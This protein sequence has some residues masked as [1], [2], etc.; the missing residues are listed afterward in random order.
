MLT[1]ERAMKQIRN[2]SIVLLLLCA[3]STIVAQQAEPQYTNVWYRFWQ[4]LDREFTASDAGQ[5]L[6]NSVLQQ[7][8]SSLIESINKY[9]LNR[10]FVHGITNDKAALLIKT[11]MGRFINRRDRIP[12]KFKYENGILGFDERLCCVGCVYWGKLPLHQTSALGPERGKQGGEHANCIQNDTSPLLNTYIKHI[13]SGQN[14][15]DRVYA[16]AKPVAA[17]TLIAAG[18]FAAW[19]YKYRDKI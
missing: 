9:I 6:K 8:N 13:A 10:F 2:K 3:V 16:K 17:L 12:V 4:Y 19:Q 7:S 15:R 1:G 5:C 14:S 11:R 18:G